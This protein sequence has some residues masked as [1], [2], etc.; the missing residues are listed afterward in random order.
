ML[1][2]SLLFYVN[3]F[4]ISCQREE[5]CSASFTTYK[6]SAST[7]DNLEYG[8]IWHILCNINVCDNLCAWLVSCCNISVKHC[9]GF[10]TRSEERRVGKECRYPWPRYGN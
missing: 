6:A 7:L 2:A 1:L 5:K 4:I 10:F 8:W 3:H 9:R